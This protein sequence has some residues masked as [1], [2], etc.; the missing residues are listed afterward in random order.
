MTSPRLGAEGGAFTLDGRRIFLYDGE[1][2]YFRVRP[3]LWRPGLER[4]KAAGMNAVSTYLPWVWHEPEEGQFDFTGETRPG[5]DLRR[6]LEECREVGLSVMARP[7]PLIYAEFDGLGL[8]PWLGDR[9]P[10]TVV[11]RRDG[12]RE[13]GA[14]F[15]SHGDI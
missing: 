8:P 5:R 11:V 2:H 12:R 10:E 15:W 1:L 6:F 3:D 13:Q 4:L 9:Y 14:F 7:G